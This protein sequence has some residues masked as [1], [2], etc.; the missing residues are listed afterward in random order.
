MP[1]SP[2]LARHPAALGQSQLVG[3]GPHARLQDSGK[4]GAS[5]CRNEPERVDGLGA[6]ARR[7]RHDREL[8]DRMAVR[9]EQLRVIERGLITL[10]AAVRERFQEGDQI[11]LL[12]PGQEETLDVGIQVAGYA[13]AVATWDV[14]AIASAVVER[15]DLPQ[16]R[17]PAV[18][19]IGPGQRHVP[20]RGRLEGTY[21]RR[22]Q[23]IDVR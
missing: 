7:I 5:D 12:L 14:D 13:R 10:Y 11:Q 21:H 2:L 9:D 15:D 16:R 6:E 22:A 4:A 19:E 3:E 1:G 8:I 18:V 17:L 20:E 23:S